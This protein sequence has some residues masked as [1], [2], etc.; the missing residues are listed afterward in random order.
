VLK[1]I[2]ESERKNDHSTVLL[3]R[4]EEKQLRR[5]RKDG[6]REKK[7]FVSMPAMNQGIDGIIRAITA[8]RAVE[9]TPSLW[10]HLKSLPPE[11]VLP[12]SKY[13]EILRYTARRI[14]VKMEEAGLNADTW[15]SYADFFT[16]ALMAYGTADAQAY[17]RI[18]ERL[19]GAVLGFPSGAQPL[20]K[21]YLNCAIAQRTQWKAEVA[22]YVAKNPTGEFPQL[23]R[24][25]DLEYDDS[26]VAVIQ[27][28]PVSEAMKVLEKLPSNLSFA[29][30]RAIMHLRLCN[31]L[32]IPACAYVSSGYCCDTCHLRGIYVGFQAMLYD[33][34]E[35]E[36][37]TG[38]ATS[39]RSDAQISKKKTYG[40]DICMACAVTFYSQQRELLFGLLRSP[41]KSYSFGHAAGVHISEA[42]YHSRRRAV[43]SSGSSPSFPLSREHS[44][45]E[46]RCFLPPPLTAVLT[47]ERRL[48][49]Q[50][51]S[52]SSPV[53][54]PAK[55][56]ASD[57]SVHITASNL[58]SCGSSAAST[59]SAAAE[60]SAVTGVEKTQRPPVRPPS[61]KMSTGLDAPPPPT[62]RCA[63]EDVMC[64]SLHVTI[65]PYGARPIAWVLSRAEKLVH[66]NTLE[67]VLVQRIG[68][69]S[70]WRSQVRVEGV[71]AMQQRWAN[72]GS[73]R[74]SGSS[75]RDPA[76]SSGDFLSSQTPPTTAWLT[77]APPLAGE[78]P[79]NLMET[80]SPVQAREALPPSTM[81]PGNNYAMG[82]D[83][84]M[85]AICL[86]PFEG[87]QPVI[88]TK[89]HHWFHVTCIGEYAR[90]AEDVCPL[91]RAAHALPDMSRSTALKNNAFKITVELTE[92]QR[93][94]PYVD[95]CVGAAVT[96]DGNYRNATSIAAAQ[97]V[98]VYPNQL[99][100]CQAKSP[101][102]AA[103]A[104]PVTKT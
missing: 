96:R 31:P 59:D 12:Q 63:T 84:E 88:E 23:E 77:P 53:G 37:A 101:V 48:S 61:R 56:P 55:V 69:A 33:E 92:E 38:P 78:S 82:S 97:C 22:S 91:C 86:C 11:D 44:K 41:H 15:R 43:S 20:L 85:C 66:L 32:P 24:V 49:S 64:I 16:Q 9:V 99:R 89:C 87:E 4:H 26:F 94:L 8:E 100:N 29:H 19:L 17:L 74:S 65:A 46:H 75:F 70:Q 73:R 80:M 71:S 3:N 40:F 95:V 62:T 25:P 7:R 13:I 10:A 27:A 14:L 54:S 5:K 52:S 93:H 2:K 90:I 35:G 18:A 76:V 58:S 1:A 79:R 102:K 81:D 28:K 34:E 36:A 72:A 104:L 60:R 30:R 47:H 68:P 50:S 67:E 39:V 83:C 45:M 42:R 98:R 21:A 51:R 6:E 57:F 103:S